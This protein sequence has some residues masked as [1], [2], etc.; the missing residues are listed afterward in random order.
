MKATD[1]C[2]QCG[3]KFGEPVFGIVI[4]RF[5]SSDYCT[6]CQVFLSEEAKRS[7]EN[8]EREWKRINGR[9]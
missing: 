1:K 3:Y 5:D 7:R 9:W 2:V 4:H 8:D 6:F